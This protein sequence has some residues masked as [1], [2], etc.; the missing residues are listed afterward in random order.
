MVCGQKDDKLDES[1]KNCVNF[2]QC[3]ENLGRMTVTNHAW[4]VQ[5]VRRWTN[6]QE[7]VKKIYYLTYLTGFAYHL[8]KGVP[9]IY[10]WLCKNVY[11]P[12]YFVRCATVLTKLHLA[13]RQVPSSPHPQCNESVVVKGHG[14]ER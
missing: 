5:P 3:I 1:W 6:F 11:N 10:P 9:R 8:S 13:H 14:S 2:P 7:V 12:A 4:Q